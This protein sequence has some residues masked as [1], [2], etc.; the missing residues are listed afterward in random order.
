MSAV[1]TIYRYWTALLFFAVLVQIGAAGYGAFNASDKSDP[2]PLQEKT[3]DNGFD[4][5]NGFGYIIFI[6]AVILF[7]LALAGRLGKQ[8][9]LRTLGLAV[10]V[11]IQIVLAW[12][13]EDHPVVGIFHPLNAFLIAGFTGSLAFAAWRKVRAVS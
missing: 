12:A 3:F 7:L 5:H 9:V 10:L 11:A 8:Q 13:G 6:G 2:G 4:F 1:R